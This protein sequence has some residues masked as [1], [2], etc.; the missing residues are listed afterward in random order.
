ADRDPLSFSAPAST[1]RGTITIDALTGAFT[2]TPTAAGRGGIA[3]AR[4]G[5]S[6]AEHGKTGRSGRENTEA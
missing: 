2:Y 1:A 4:R 5:Y 3:R 6:C